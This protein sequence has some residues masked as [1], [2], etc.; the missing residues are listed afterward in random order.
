MGAAMG[1]DCELLE[2]V[3]GWVNDAANIQFG[4]DDPEHRRHHVPGKRDAGLEASPPSAPS[5]PSWAS[6]ST[7]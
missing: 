5:S 7:P 6:A 4:Q 1:Q 3:C 2:E